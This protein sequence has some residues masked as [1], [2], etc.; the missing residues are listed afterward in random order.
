MS[1][2]PASQWFDALDAP[3][4]DP[5]P[6]PV[7]R[8][9]EA[10]QRALH[11]DDERRLLRTEAAIAGSSQVEREAL[12]EWLGG[13]L[14]RPP[15]E[16]PTAAWVAMRALVEALWWDLADRTPDPLEPDALSPNI[17]PNHPWGE[18]AES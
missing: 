9:A 14:H 13:M 11:A 2:Q 6:S 10:I 7:E 4:P 15:L 8:V 5:R 16:K 12:C 3:P 17:L 1:L 18:G